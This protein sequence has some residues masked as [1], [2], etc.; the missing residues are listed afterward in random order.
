[1]R[2]SWSH[3]ASSNALPTGRRG[4]SNP[5]RLPAKYSTSCR[6]TSANPSSHRC[7]RSAGTS[8][9][10]DSSMWRPT[11][12]P[13]SRTA[14]S[15]PMG[16]GTTVCVRVVVVRV[17]VNVSMTGRRAGDAE[18]DL[19]PRRGP[20]RRVPTTFGR[21][22]TGPRRGAHRRRVVVPGARRRR[23]VDGRGSGDGVAPAGP[24]AAVVALLAGDPTQLT[25]DEVAGGARAHGHAQGCQLPGQVL[26]VGAGGG[27]AGAILL[28]LHAVA[29]G[30]A[31][32]GQQDQRR[33]VGGLGGEG[34]I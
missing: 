17:I 21:R 14:V 12:A 18:R 4:R 26:R 19:L 27:G 5:V 33:G 23:Q 10:R 8:G 28:G 29:V 20:Y 15:G 3:T 34:Q 6:T 30:L 1:M 25:A 16:E 2:V 7:P 22:R 31:V 32:L 13:P 24:V 11:S 9:R